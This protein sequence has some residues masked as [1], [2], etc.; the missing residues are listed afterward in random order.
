MTAPIIQN[1]QHEGWDNT[2]QHA[3]RGAV[4]KTSFYRSPSALPMHFAEYFGVQG[5]GDDTTFKGVG[6]VFGIAA[7]KPGITIEQKGCL[8]T[9]AL[10]VAPAFD[11]NNAPLD[12]ATCLILENAGTGMATELLYFGGGL[13][14]LDPCAIAA[15][16]FEANYIT[17]AWFIGHAG[18]VF[19]C[20]RGLA[21]PAVIDHAF[22]RIPPNTVAFEARNA[23]NTADVELLGV[24]DDLPTVAALKVRKPV[25]YTPTVA[26]QTGALGAGATGV[27]GHS[28]WSQIN[29]RVHVDACAY[30]GT[31]PTG[32]G[33]FL[34]GL[35]KPALHRAVLNGHDTLTGWGVY[36]E[37]LPGESVARCRYIHA[38]SPITNGNYVFVSGS[39]RPEVD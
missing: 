21:S 31:S 2:G 20:S 8:Y 22:A 4:Q 32:S 5:I 35:P 16:G 9:M 11:R 15:I 26:A 27:P 39:Y 13:H 10:A 36:G 14:D 18:H 30:V 1:N 28:S 6:G 17:V 37:I 7:D 12:D 23:A 38:A 33:A 3:D 29:G 34:I 19:D 25:S 24:K